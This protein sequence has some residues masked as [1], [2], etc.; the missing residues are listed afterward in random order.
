MPTDNSTASRAINNQHNAQ[1]A[2]SSKQFQE[3]CLEAA[4]SFSER[5]L[6]IMD[7]LGE[8]LY[9]MA[10]H[11]DDHELRRTYFAALQGLYSSR[12]EIKGDFKKQFLAAIKAEIQHQPNSKIAALFA[13]AAISSVGQLP[14]RTTSAEAAS[15]QDN[16]Q[17][18][19]TGN[20]DHNNEDQHSRLARTLPKGSWIEF[21]FQG[22]PSLKARFTWVNPSS[23]VY[24]FV[25]RNGQKAPD[26][27]PAQL[28]NA[29]RG[30]SAT[31]IQSA[32]QLAQTANNHD[33]ER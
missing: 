2:R 8:T 19:A 6:S 25:D 3:Q 18:P 22:K 14:D 26:K 32:A 4:E 13:N 9:Q 15:P 10:D 5:L 1:Q 24:L 17:Q 16:Q 12:P 29:F 11:A 27:T 30:G 20:A 33:S 28:A 21:H 23:G 31:L 7:G